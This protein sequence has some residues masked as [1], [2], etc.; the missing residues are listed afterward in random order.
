MGSSLGNRIVILDDPHSDLS[1]LSKV[2][3]QT[4]GES[5]SVE[6]VVTKDALFAEIDASATVHLVVMD[7]VLEG[8]PLGALGVVRA[9]RKKVRDLPIVVV[10]EEQEASHDAE[11]VHAGATDVLIRG[12]NLEK[13][14]AT[15]MEK[16]NRLMALVER[17]RRLE[18]YNKY[19]RDIDRS[20]YRMI[21]NSPQIREVTEKI[22]RVACVPRP[23]LITGERGT[24]KELVARAIHDEAGP[25]ADRPMIVVNCAAFSANL[26][27]SELFG[28][29][30]GAFTGADQRHRG[31]FEQADRGTLFLDEIGNMSL[32]FQKKIMRVVE[33]G[34]FRRV[35]GQAQIRVNTRIIAA[36]NADLKQR[37]KE[38]LF[39]AD[40]YDRLSF[41]VIHVPPL[42]QRVGDVE[43]LARY[44]LHRFMEEVPNFQG[45]R[46]SK[47]AIEVLRRYPCPGNVRELKNIVERA[48]YRD[49]TN[50]ITTS[51]IGLQ[52]E[53][54]EM[55]AGNT[56]KE[57][58]EAFEI[59]LIEKALEGSQGNQA[60]AAR[61]LGLTYHQFRHYLKKY[62][63]RLDS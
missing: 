21:G 33:Y 56:F 54:R 18:Q 27:E 1:H 8:D 49:T 46:F 16:I 20:R 41:E 2:F 44:F 40:L 5:A 58:T 3:A 34:T 63:S 55:V 24:G 4:A 28:Y 37:I 42:R 59:H 11:L 48:V 39:L 35:G 10:V 51:D 52:N 61:Y 26:L 36:T 14:I 38:G 57:K 15:Q 29:E 45:K 43:I 7:D 19:L 50:E 60:S 9:L 47:N 22:R 25:S 30:R 6:M 12:K 23:V 31:K 17:N 53:A 62:A 32:D 13:L